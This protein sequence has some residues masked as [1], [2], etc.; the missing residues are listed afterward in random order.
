MNLD[1]DELFGYLD[2]LIER[3]DLET[4]KKARAECIRNGTNH[5][6]IDKAIRK[7]EAASNEGILAGIISG[8]FS[9]SS[10]SK[11][12]SSDIMSWEHDYIDKNEYEPYQFEEEDLED[13]DF[14]NED[15]I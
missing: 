5:D 1:D 9:G 13:D 10:K 8:L 14:Y 3:V 2:S 11:K 6:A 15:D 7:K 12:T 4:L